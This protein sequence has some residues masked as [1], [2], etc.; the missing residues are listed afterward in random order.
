MQIMMGETEIYISYLQS[1][2][3]HFCHFVQG[4]F[5][6]SSVILFSEFFDLQT[7]FTCPFFHTHSRLHI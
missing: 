4:C 7:D 3:R 2:S 5:I 1:F 6:Q